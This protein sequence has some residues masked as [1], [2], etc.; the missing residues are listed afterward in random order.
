[1][2]LTLQASF[3]Y[4]DP[5]P[6]PVDTVDIV[7]GFP[8]Y[9]VVD[10]TQAGTVSL[11]ITGQAQVSFQQRL[12]N[13][14]YHVSIPTSEIWG[15]DYGTTLV[16]YISGLVKVDS[17]FS[18]Q[19]FTLPF[20][21]R[22]GSSNS[23]EPSLFDATYFFSSAKYTK[24]Q[25]DG[26]ISI[27]Q[28]TQ[29]QQQ[30]QPR[31]N[32]AKSTVASVIFPKAMATVAESSAAASSVSSDLPASL[33]LAVAAADGATSLVPPKVNE[34]NRIVD[35]LIFCLN[36]SVYVSVQKKLFTSLVTH[37]E[38]LLLYL[39]AS[40]VDTSGQSPTLNT[41]IPDETKRG[42]FQT[43]L[44]D[45]GLGE[46]VKSGAWSAAYDSIV[47]NFA[48][49]FEFPLVM[50][51]IQPLSV[52]GV[53]H[54]NDPQQK[55][56][57]LSQFSYYHLSIN[58]AVQIGDSEPTQH[59]S[60]YDWP[61]DANPVN[62]SLSFK[63]NETYAVNSISENV[64]VTVTGYD[65]SEVFS[66]AFAPSDPILQNL[67][68]TV[69]LRLPPILTGGGGSQSSTKRIRG[70]IVGMVKTCTLKGTV[71]IQAKA[72]VEDPWSTVSTTISDKAG[73]FVLPYPFGKY[74][75]AQALTS[76]DPTAITPLKTDDPESPT[77]ESI[78]AD[79]IYITLQKSSDDETK[80]EDCGCNPT[81]TAGRLP[82]QDDLIQSDQY[83]Q[84]VGGTCM[85]LSVPN[86]TLREFAYTAVVRN[87]DPDVANY[88]LSSTEF[89]DDHGV[90]NVNYQ[91][92]SLG[93]V[94]RRQIDLNNPIRWE[95]VTGLANETLYEAVTV[96]TGH[97]LHYRSEFRADG[98]SLGN[99]L[100]SLPLAPGQKKQIVIFDNAH[101]FTG[102]QTQSI[103]QTEQLTADIVSQR[104]VIDQIAGNISE[105]LLGSSEADTGGVAAA[106]GAHGSAGSFGAN[107]GVAGGYAKSSSS[108]SQTSGRDLGGFFQENLRQGI[109]QNAQAYRR[110]NSAVVTTSKEAQ[111]FQAETTVVSNH[112]HCHTI[113]IMHYEVLRHFAVY[114]ELVDVEECV[115]IPFPLTK[116]TVLNIAKWADAL[117]LR[118]LPLHSNSYKDPNYFYGSGE[119]HPLYPAFD[120]LER[121]R[122]N[123]EL[124][125]WPDGPYCKE[126]VIWVQ[127]E[128]TVSI[129][130]PRPA[131]KYDLIHSLPIITEHREEDQVKYWL[132]GLF[133]G[134]ISLSWGNSS[135]EDRNKVQDISN[136][137][138][139]LDAGYENRPLANSIRLQTAQPVPL[140]KNSDKIID[141]VDLFYDTLTDFNTWLVYV[142]ILRNPAKDPNGKEGLRKLMAD[143]FVGNTLAEWTTNWNTTLIPK[144]WKRMVDSLTVDG[145]SV[146]FTD[147]SSYKGGRQFVTLSVSGKGQ[148]KREDIQ[149][150]T[151]SSIDNNIKKLAQSN[152]EW[153]LK[154]L[155]LSYSTKHFNG[156]L[157]NGSVNN[158]FL[159]G[160]T[161]YFPLT[162]AE[163]KNPKQDDRW[164]SQRLISH[165][166]RN[167]EYY[168]RVL[169][170]SLDPQ[171]RFMLLDGF[172]IQVYEED[173]TSAGYHSLSSVLK[174]SPVTIVGN[175]MVF[176]VSPGYKVDRSLILNS[177]RGEGPGASSLL[178]LYRPEI[179]PP[180][181]RISVPS[182]GVYSESMM[183]NCDSCEKLKPDSS[184]DWTK[185]T[186]DEPTAINALQAPTVQ[187]PTVYNPTVKDLTTPI[188]NIQSAPT[189]PDVGAGLKSAGLLEVLG[190]SGAFQD[191]TGLTGNQAN[192]AST[193]KANIE[194]A[195]AAAAGTASNAVAQ[196]HNTSNSS[197]I[198]G[199][200][201]SATDSG[202]L[203]KAEAGQLVK[204]HIQSQIDGGKSQQAAIELNK[205][206][207]KPSLSDA[208]VE[209][210][211]SN[212]SVEAST[213]DVE[214]NSSTVKISP[215]SSKISLQAKVSLA[216]PIIKQKSGT[217]TCWAAAA[218][219]LM[220]WKAEQSLTT[221]EAMLRA[222]DKYS[223]MYA[224]NQGLLSADKDDF[225]KAI[226][227]VSEGPT[228]HAP[229]DFVA[230]M[231]AYG[232]IW[233]TTD[234]KPGATF[235]PH[236]KILIQIDGDGNDNG[237]N[238]IFTWINPAN[239]DTPRQSYKDFIVGYDEM[240]TDNHGA[241]FTQIVHF[242]ELLPG[243]SKP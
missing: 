81:T 135:G 182:K 217:P 116:F 98:Y 38:S 152:V 140:T 99:L 113:T 146:D 104:D 50:P 21:V 112:N 203:T 181:Y 229:S 10:N 102:S 184:Q 149:F 242:E 55:V 69:N 238:T 54:I 237:A 87:S 88:R 15:P 158:D 214:G 141:P 19:D 189:A 60:R 150:V 124:V 151:I 131:T 26:Q 144:I 90:R 22:Y 139:K 127:G 64:T 77:D 84:D 129:N 46:I 243:A 138:I 156:T 224:A 61:S 219:M 232:P 162:E 71:I 41:T 230:W 193:Y 154:S 89:I 117:S 51:R 79:F 114:Q 121:V 155:R 18:L 107:I 58:F 86:R 221:E 119:R 213:T 52:T 204:E 226:H 153:I 109:H 227:M 231:K 216:V 148:A 186:T 43:T 167:L 97:I 185:F 70:K 12:S 194:A 196:A 220:S 17:K 65:N 183:G 93:K 91:L 173:G 34:S 201:T 222:G 215:G 82:G 6:P 16:K 190:K 157:H 8:R 126:Q 160:I 188:I 197:A 168:N 101:S 92:T 13:K 57:T 68:I 118:L 195:Q 73:N 207:A 67:N 76:L 239:G 165:L 74:V 171:R 23:S 5:G 133:T 228:S 85:N 78:S 233:V 1:M 95:D 212:K 191:I 145:L 143:Y 174:N 11:A 136:N 122:T 236:A 32:L 39:I 48:Q 187:A 178:D 44:N 2:V 42:T 3:T 177:I 103:S 66:K 125:D 130:I 132:L 161:I 105:Q 159:D 137:I 45:F 75:A 200:I 147:P 7:I 20:A 211:K 94:A 120:A 63:F 169:L 29:P 202:F 108:A 209:A 134:G 62:N 47:K 142:E 180:P 205:S 53:F 40:L 164:L 241:L 234:A 210:V 198:M 4:D 36:K 225:V 24:K 14:Q 83:T 123:W 218:A 166:N 106:A 172:H 100:Y 110:Q 49:F 176:P 240:V 56:L 115:F 235:S 72:K 33:F 179:P 128:A 223:Q 170:Y 111:N 9:E 30:S 175:S 199:T 96:A 208:A 31:L 25:E 28:Q 192:T 59:I 80:K 37:D 35:S 27:Q 206:A 163:L